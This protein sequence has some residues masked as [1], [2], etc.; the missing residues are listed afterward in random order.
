MNKAIPIPEFEK[1]QQLPQ[2]MLHPEPTLLDRWR[3]IMRYKWGVLGLAL[4]GLLI[5][6]VQAFTATPIY[7]ATSTLLVEP[8]QPKVVNIQSLEGPTPL[9]L[10]YE[11]QYEIIRSRAIT[12][13]VVDRM[14]LASND[15][16]LG[17]D[18]GA[19]GEGISSAWADWFP[20]HNA[21]NDPDFRRN[22]AIKILQ[23]NLS[24]RGGQKS[25]IVV[26][27]YEDPDPKMA[28]SI[29]NGVSKAY[30][31]YG[32]E[33]RLATVKEATSWLSERLQNLRNQL[34]QSELSLQAFQTRESMV[35]SKNRR[36]ILETKIANQASQLVKA[37]TERAEAEIRYNQVQD[38]RALGRSYE[39]LVPL[40]Q[41]APLERLL[42]EFGRLER[43]LSELSERYGGKHPK[44]IAARA[45]RDE[46]ERRLKLEINRSADGIRKVFEAAT[47][48]ETEAQRQ[49]Q[50]QQDEMQNVTGKGFQHAKLEREVETNRQLYDTFLARF[51]EIDSAGES[52]QTNVRVIDTANV[53]ALPHKPNKKRILIVSLILGLFAGIA[54]AFLRAHLDNTFKKGADIE[55]KLL[56]P[57]LSE[58]AQL[59]PAKGKALIPERYVL[60]E[61]RAAFS[62]AI[63]HI[64]TGIKFSNLDAPLKSIAVTSSQPGEGKTTLASNLAISFAQLGKTLLLDADMRKPDIRRIMGWE[65]GPGLSEWIS[66]R[67][68]LDNVIRQDELCPDLHIMTT[69]AIPPN[70]LELLSSN[71]FRKH[72]NEL[73]QQYD[74]VIIDTP[75]VMPVS[76]ALVLGNLVDGVIVSVKFD[77]TS[78]P[79]AQEMVK[80]L[81]S[82]HI[83][84]LGAVLSMVDMNKLKSYY[85]SHYYNSYYG[86]YYGKYYGEKA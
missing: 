2:E 38:A 19:Q 69:G 31:Q 18:A 15:R 73:V 66:G 20:E 42:E 32:L 60:H 8:A 59:K 39:V 80:R 5:G 10:F 74:Y 65:A 56:L 81:R 67:A 77:V 11:T 85:G 9:M 13:T 4:L 7:K 44:M 57:V 14:R 55:E 79:L 52:E 27:H 47:A 17:L 36:T 41:S 21:D 22:S 61:Q 33:S 40:L 71:T 46:A 43:K 62:E 78:H 48:R 26:I 24:V 35:D 1:E 54:L 12:E 45:D 3:I 6:I 23:E 72:F 25:Q 83:E 50:Q 68:E 28:A 84:P 29:A 53:P 86:G 75:P 82:N 64:R 30:T 58:L 76:D 16:F 37:Q 34:E 49:I 51:K 70:P 63:N